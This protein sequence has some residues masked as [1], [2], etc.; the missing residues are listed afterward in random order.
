MQNPNLEI[1]EAWRRKAEEDY[2][3]AGVFVTCH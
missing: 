1:F 3:A 2:A